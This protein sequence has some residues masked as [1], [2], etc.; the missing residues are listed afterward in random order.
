MGHSI[1]MLIFTVVIGELLL[2]AGN[3]PLFRFIENWIEEDILYKMKQDRPQQ[4]ERFKLVGDSDVN[5]M[6]L[7]NVCTKTLEQNQ[8]RQI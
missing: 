5:V 6:D 3:L 1:R 7:M 8:T 4:I 2:L